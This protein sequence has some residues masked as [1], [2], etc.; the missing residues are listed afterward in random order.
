MPIIPPR[1]SKS[2]AE[3][4]P[5]VP[6]DHN[7]S[8]PELVATRKDTVDEL[9]D[10]YDEELVSDV[11]E[12][13]LL[14]K[15]EAAAESN[16]AEMVPMTSSLTASPS[17]GTPPTIPS[18]RP[19]RNQSNPER[20]R[21][22][23]SVIPNQEKSPIESDQDIPQIPT[24][25][26]KPRKENLASSLTPSIPTSRPVKE[27]SAPLT[28]EKVADELKED[29]SDTSITRKVS[30]SSVLAS[31]F[32]DTTAQELATALSL[33]CSL[34][35]SLHDEE[36][37]GSGTK[38]KDC[39]VESVVEENVTGTEHSNTNLKAAT[40]ASTSEISKSGIIDSQSQSLDPEIDASEKDSKILEVSHGTITS[41]IPI[42]P[43]VRP[44]KPKQTDL[45]ETLEHKAITGEDKPEDRLEIF[46]RSPIQPTETET[47]KK[48]TEN[49]IQQPENSLGCESEEKKEGVKVAI[50]P[51]LENNVEE[52]IANINKAIDEPSVSKENP[53]EDRRVIPEKTT[54]N[55]MTLDIPL[56]HPS[57][58][59]LKDL[60][61]ENQSSSSKILSET[62]KES[63][64]SVPHIPL[65]RPSK[66]LTSD[67]SSPNVEIPLRPLRSSSFDSTKSIPQ[68]KPPPKPKHLSSKIAAFQ[69]MF[70]AE[71]VSLDENK[72]PKAP[73]RTVTKLSS[74][75]LKFTEGLKLGGGVPLPGMANPALLQKLKTRNISDAEV[76]N[77]NER[78]DDDNDDDNNDDNDDDN[79]DDTTAEKTIPV[80]DARKSRVRLR[81]KRLPKS[82]QIAV[83]ISTS[84][85]TVVQ[86][87][88]WALE[89][90]KKAD[91]MI[92]PEIL[93]SSKSRD[94][95]SVIEDDKALKELVLSPKDEGKQRVETNKTNEH[96]GCEH[97]IS[98]NESDEID[99]DDL[100]ET[101]WDDY[102]FTLTGEFTVREKNECTNS[103][104]DNAD[105]KESEPDDT[106]Q[107][108]SLKDAI[109]GDE[110]VKTK[111]AIN[112]DKQNA[113][114]S[115]SSIE[116]ETPEAE[117]QPQEGETEYDDLE[118]NTTTLKED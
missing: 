106:T 69:Q 56:A 65:I 55:S 75:K 105:F 22:E 4:I 63:E 57:K 9:L 82:A 68:K 13:P 39:S 49:V 36:T 79:D 32:P 21:H 72:A 33:N 34:S 52:S 30:E 110:E 29:N 19:Q 54:E 71:P 17:T 31:K 91:H 53:A 112:L 18:L 118:T 61:D 116:H 97:A 66:K 86:G 5:V 38:V 108:E 85:F 47:E 3:V 117:S 99:T 2:D 37:N 93:D 62:T 98:E 100:Y 35:E 25:R 96:R 40:L 104:P 6:D 81:G 114:L 24:S 113:P 76:V 51:D 23:D 58:V 87:D 103:K 50:E 46:K 67:E 41:S 64:T 44:S 89:Y 115:S 83:E 12:E 7:G 73:T 80:S 70:N 16:V 109:V 43:L 88:L 84:R 15:S 78:N 42:I 92:E 1:P 77:A 14:S 74:E 11:V 48:E 60:E 10:Y 94:T 59:A 26:P 27:Q 95:E 28:S 102:N 101:D 8:S 90:S 45:K 107:L 20:T 111:H